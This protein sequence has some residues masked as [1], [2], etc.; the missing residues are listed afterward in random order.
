MFDQVR[1]DH[2]KE[3]VLLQ[4]VQESLAHLRRNVDID[5]HRQTE[6][7][8]VRKCF[9]YSVCKSAQFYLLCRAKYIIFL[10][11]ERIDIVTT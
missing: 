1:T 10:I 9:K 8:H 7:R 2:G 11:S 3:F 6:S 5:P 4:F